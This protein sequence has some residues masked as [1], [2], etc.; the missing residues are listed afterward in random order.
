MEVLGHNEWPESHEYSRHPRDSL[1]NKPVSFR[2]ALLGDRGGL[3]CGDS[4]VA[5]GGRAGGFVLSVVL[6]N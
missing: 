4:S 1:F 2:G 5:A 6:K 3:V